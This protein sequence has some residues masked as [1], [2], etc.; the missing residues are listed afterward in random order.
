VQENEQ[1]EEGGENGM[2]FIWHIYIRGSVMKLVS[3]IRCRVSPKFN[4]KINSQYG[5]L[6][7]A[8]GSVRK[9]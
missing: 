9:G 8:C 4:R 2:R 1:I 3:V 6:M 7:V 5:K